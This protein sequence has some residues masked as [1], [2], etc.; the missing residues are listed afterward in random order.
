MTEHRRLDEAFDPSAYGRVTADDYDDLYAGLDPTAAVELLAELA[1]G[2]SVVEFGIGTGRLALPLAQRGLVVH[3]IEGSPKMAE[4]LRRKPGGH[5]L[6]VVIGDFAEVSAGTGF[7]LAV[8]VF[9]TVF[10]LPS[11]DA[12]VRCFRNAAAH[13]RQGGRFVVEAWVPDVGSF[14]NGTA[15]RP[16]TV[17]DER[18]EL[19]VARLQSATQTMWTTKVHLTDAGVRLVPANHRY[20][21]PAEMDLMARLAGLRLEQRWSSWDR[22]AFT[23]D[24]PAHVSVWRKVSDGPW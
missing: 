15:V 20:A 24:S 5:A 13:L 23:D 14:R 16:V 7:S 17:R 2:G 21:W 18:V 4:S 11:Q 12:Q 22:E 6:P 9:N 8:L 19:E 1:A 3:G 10:A